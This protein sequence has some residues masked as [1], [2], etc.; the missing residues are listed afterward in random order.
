MALRMQCS[1]VRALVPCQRVRVGD[2]VPRRRILAGLPY[3]LNEGRTTCSA[4]LS[5]RGVTGRREH[6]GALLKANVVFVGIR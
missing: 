1:P 4:V 5:S 2:S 6:K 3:R